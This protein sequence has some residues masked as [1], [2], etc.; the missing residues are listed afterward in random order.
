MV[1]TDCL[2]GPGGA[3]ACHRKLELAWRKRLSEESVNFGAIFNLQNNAVAQA[4]MKIDIAVWNSQIH[5][6]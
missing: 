5:S 2:I 4:K 3:A 1:G 6:C